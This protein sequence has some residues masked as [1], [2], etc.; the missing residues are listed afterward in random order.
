MNPVV[1]FGSPSSVAASDRRLLVV[2]DGG[3]APGY[4]SVAVALTEEGTRR[5]YEVWAAAEGFKSLTSDGAADP[6]FERLIIG[7][8]ER[9]ALLAKGIPARSMG[10]RLL[11]AGSDFRT[12][13]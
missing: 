1:A 13:R 6:R 10:R 7:R 9:Y 2:F 5:G 8:K 4:A 12:E 11:D 3:D